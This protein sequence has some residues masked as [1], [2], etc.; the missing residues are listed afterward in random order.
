MK[1][2]SDK[3]EFKGLDRLINVLKKNKVEIN[4]GILGDK[5]NRSSDEKEASS[6]ATIGLVHEF[7]SFEKNIPM[8]SFLRMPLSQHLYDKLNASGFFKKEIEE[9]IKENGL[10]GFADKIAIV[11]ENTVKEAFATGGFG[12]WEPSNMKYKKVQMTLVE[13][14]Q[15]RNSIISEVKIND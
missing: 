5:D 12:E 14:Q 3:I 6:N 2:D 7:G 13:T 10:K 15:L 9:I 1:I 8:R 4:V 11:A